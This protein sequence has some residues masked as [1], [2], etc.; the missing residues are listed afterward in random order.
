MIVVIETLI[1][2]YNLKIDFPCLMTG[3]VRFVVY[4]SLCS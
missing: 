2:L 1:S 4:E 3:H